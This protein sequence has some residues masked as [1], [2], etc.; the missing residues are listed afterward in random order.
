MRVTY[1]RARDYLQN[2]K[3]IKLHKKIHLRLNLRKGSRLYCKRIFVTIKTLPLPILKN[4]LMRKLH[5]IQNQPS[6][7]E[8]SEKYTVST[9][10]DSIKVTYHTND[11]RFACQHLIFNL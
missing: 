6:R 9:Y 10:L 7:R 5:L 8:I 1:L 3:R 2:L 11:S 4:T